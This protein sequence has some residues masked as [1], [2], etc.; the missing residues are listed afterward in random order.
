MS[1]PKLIKVRRD[2]LEPHP[3]LANHPTAAR[4]I[5]ILKEST[6]DK[7]VQVAQATQLLA[8]FTDSTSTVGI[9]D[10]IHICPRADRPGHFWVLDG[11]HRMEG[12]T[13]TEFEAWLHQESEAESIILSAFFDRRHLTQDQLAWFLINKWPDL[14][15]SEDRKGGRPK[16]CS[17]AERFSLRGVSDR[18]GVRLAD[19]SQAAKLYREA[20][21]KKRLLQT[22]A[23]VACGRKLWALIAGIGYVDPNGENPPRPPF[24]TTQTDKKFRSFYKGLR[25]ILLANG[26]EAEAA[27]EEVKGN[28]VLVCRDGN[29]DR[30]CA[31]KLRNLLKD[32]I[33]QAEKAGQ[34]SGE[35]LDPELGDE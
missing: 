26:K 5:E 25:E 21:K 17:A 19:L 22:S 20:K 2:Q 13:A 16:N 11:R 18:Y 10:P 28:L 4:C 29:N 15:D 8:R 9:L 34:R 3:D 14:A 23:S 35:E 33:K 31:V 27:L 24:S 1:A 6:S 7:E 30:G 32:I 12:S